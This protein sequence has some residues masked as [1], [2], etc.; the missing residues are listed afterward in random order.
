MG[1]RLSR[2]VSGECWIRETDRSGYLTIEIDF[3][4]DGSKYLRCCAERIFVVVLQGNEDWLGPIGR[5]IFNFAGGIG[6]IAKPTSS[7]LPLG[8]A[9]SYDKSQGLFSSLLINLLPRLYYDCNVNTRFTS[10]WHDLHDNYKG[11]GRGNRE[12][13]RCCI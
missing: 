5:D 13:R 2:L 8:V 12:H 11:K 3:F 1:F 10:V 4:L 7:T 6:T 9:T